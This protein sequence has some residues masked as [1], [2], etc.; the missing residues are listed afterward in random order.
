M[1]NKCNKRNNKYNKRN[2]KYNIETGVKAQTIG[3]ENKKYVVLIENNVSKFS[4]EEIRNLGKMIEK[5]NGQMKKLYYAYNIP[6]MNTR[7]RTFKD[8]VRI[9]FSKAK[10]TKTRDILNLRMEKVR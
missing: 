10:G 7:K 8:L 2:N 9:F 4:E 6:V 1:K 5:E 3:M